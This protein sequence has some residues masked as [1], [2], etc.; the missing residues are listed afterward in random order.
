MND[1]R[2]V[3]EDERI[4]LN[5]VIRPHYKR[6]KPNQEGKRNDETAEVLILLQKCSL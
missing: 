2:K 5:I 6:V 4:K 1:R 3:G